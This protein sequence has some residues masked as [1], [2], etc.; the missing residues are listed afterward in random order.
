MKNQKTKKLKEDQKLA[1]SVLK[2]Y[3]IYR[4]K[5]IQLENQ[6][7]YIDEEQKDLLDKYKSYVNMIDC[8]LDELKPDSKRIIKDKFLKYITINECGYS[9]GT[10]YSKLREALNDFLDYYK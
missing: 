5:I 10:Y 4:F 8:I 1:T 6:I 3:K 9:K 2:K 7:K